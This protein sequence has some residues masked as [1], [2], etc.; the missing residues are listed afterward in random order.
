MLAHQRRLFLSVCIPLAEIGY[1]VNRDRL[2]A[3][4][5]RL[6]SKKPGSGLNVCFVGT[7]AE[8]SIAASG[9]NMTEIRTLSPLS[10]IF[11]LLP[12]FL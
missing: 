12:G 5:S 7:E 6:R 3:L 11:D 4:S 8:E 9:R 1:H 10:R 2:T